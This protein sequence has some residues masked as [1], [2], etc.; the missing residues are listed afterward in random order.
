MSMDGVWM[1]SYSIDTDVRRWTYRLIGAV[2]LAIPAV[3]EKAR[4]LFGL[5]PHWG[6]PISSGALFGALYFFFDKWG[7]RWGVKIFGVPD[8]NGKWLATGVSSYVDPDTQRPMNF[9]MK[10]TIKQ[11]LSKLEVFTETNDSTSRSTMASICT[12]HAV[13]IFRYAFENVPKNLANAELQRHPGLIEL[14]IE[15]KTHMIGDYFSGKHRL[16]FGELRL[17]KE[18]P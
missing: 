11:T 9:E 15:D 1:H 18:K 2:A 5:S 6:F 17:V 3:F 8:L 13:P 7:W 4:T 14:R 10:V 12:D 16:R